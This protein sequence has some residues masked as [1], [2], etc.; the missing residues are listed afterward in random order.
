[1]HRRLRQNHVFV[2]ISP[3]ITVCC[4]YIYTKVQKELDYV[5]M[6]CTHCIVQGCNALIVGSAGIIHLREATIK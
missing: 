4:I 1:M 5:L 2:L 3:S 6:S